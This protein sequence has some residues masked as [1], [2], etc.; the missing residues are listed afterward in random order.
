MSHY[1]RDAD[2]AWLE[3]AGFDGRQVDVRESE[4]GL[5]ETDSKT[6]AVVAVEFWKA[7]SALPSELLQALAAPAA[8]PAVI[9]TERAG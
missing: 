9:E 8:Q 7:S 1:D 3:L 2:I 6:G 4:W 5:V